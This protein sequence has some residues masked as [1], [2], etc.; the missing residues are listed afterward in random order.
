MSVL[1]NSCSE[2]LHVRMSARSWRSGA[3]HLTRTHNMRLDNARGGSWWI[4]AGQVA[5][6]VTHRKQA[7]G[8]KGTIEGA[9]SGAGG[10]R[11]QAAD[12]LAAKSSSQGRPT[13]A[14]ASAA[15]ATMLSGRGSGVDRGASQ[16]GR[17][18]L[19]VPILTGSRHSLRD[20]VLGLFLCSCH[21]GVQSISRHKHTDYCMA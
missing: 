3:W 1:H 21:V 8:W 5:R 9:D 4:P 19:E 20:R 18:R 2:C 16:P 7:A 11:R 13:S 10:R 14:A 12:A 17:A 6:C 15:A